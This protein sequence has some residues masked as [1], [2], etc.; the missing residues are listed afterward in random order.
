MASYR[1]CCYRLQTIDPTTTD[2]LPNK[3]RRLHERNLL[4]HS[5]AKRRELITRALSIRKDV[6]QALATA[7]QPHQ[8][9]SNRKK[10]LPRE[11]RC[12]HIA[13][14]YLFTDPGKWIKTCLHGTR[15]DEY[16]PAKCLITKT[17]KL[18][19]ATTNSLGHYIE[20]EMG[21]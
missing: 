19:V 18:Y 15:D 21:T 6:V 10:T 8:H 2:A 12:I 16:Q 5:R 14:G 13:E 3:H 1:C 4:L 9:E 11:Y 7:L 20:S 17:H